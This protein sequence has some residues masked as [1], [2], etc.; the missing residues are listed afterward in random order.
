M[1]PAIEFTGPVEHCDACERPL[2]D[3]PGFGDVP[4]LGTGAWGLLCLP[5][6][7]AA[8]VRWGSG[9]GQQYGRL[10]SGAV[11]A[12]ERCADAAG[13]GRCAVQIG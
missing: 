2:A 13:S 12:T 3:E 5:C 7:A 6:C 8:Q 4:V 1:T 11:A 9:S 10:P